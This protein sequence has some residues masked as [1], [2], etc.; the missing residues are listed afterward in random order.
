MSRRF[1]LLTIIC[2]VA[3][4]AAFVSHSITS[5]LRIET[6]PGGYWVIGP[7]EGEASVFMA[8]SSLARD[9]LSWQLIASRLNR[10]IEGWGIAGS[11]PQ[12]WE[13]FQHLETHTK[14]TILVVSLYDLNEYFLSD[15]RAQV[16]PLTQTIEDLWQTDLDWTFHKRVLSEYPLTYVRTLLPTAGRST[17]VIRGLREKAESYLNPLGDKEAEGA[18]VLSFNDF[19]KETITDW[20]QGMMLRRLVAMRIACQGRHVFNG[21]KRLAFL[22]MLH[23]AREQGSAVVVVLPV[24]SAYVKELITTEVQQHFEEVVAEAQHSFEEVHWVRLDQLDGLS[25]NEYFQDLVHMNS[26]GQKIATEALLDRIRE[27]TTLP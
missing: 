3:L 18:S 4:I 22:R 20:S 13:R 14:L 6:A 10:R 7:G 1:E 12:E 16:V 5:W 26:N 21:P 2:T 23:Q 27:F 25:T 19:K 11:S 15:Y 24:S 8:G 17:G 9:G